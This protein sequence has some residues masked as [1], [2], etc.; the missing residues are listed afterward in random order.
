MPILGV[1]TSKFR[2]GF[3]TATFQMFIITLKVICKIDFWT[4]L[5]GKHLN[6]NNFAKLVVLQCLSSLSSLSPNYA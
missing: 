4:S 5:I 2:W 1:F 6:F 3:K